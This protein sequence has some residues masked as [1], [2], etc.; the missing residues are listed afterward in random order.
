MVTYSST[1]NKQNKKTASYDPLNYPAH[2]KMSHDLTNWCF[3]TNIFTAHSPHTED[4]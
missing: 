2:S 4:D 1:L 3:I